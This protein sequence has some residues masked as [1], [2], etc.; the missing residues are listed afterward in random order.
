MQGSLQELDTANILQLIGW[1]QRS[2]ELWIETKDRGGQEQCWILF[3]E[4][5]SAIYAYSP[6][7]RLNRLQDYLLGL[8]L[9]NGLQ[10]TASAGF[11]S[12]LGGSMAEY[13]QLW[14]LLE[15]R[16]LHPPQV[17]AILRHMIQ[18]VLFEL[19]CLRQGEFSLNF[20]HTLSPQL[21]SLPL[22]RLVPVVQAQVRQWYRLFPH[23]PSL[24][25]CPRYGNP[26]DP[27]DS[28]FEIL[29]PLQPWLELQPAPSIRQIARYTQ[30]ELIHVVK[31][32]YEAI[33]N[34]LIVL[35]PRD[36]S[37]DN[38]PSDPVFKIMCVDD[39]ITACRSLEYILG[40]HGYQ[41]I[42]ITDPIEAIA[43]AFQ[44]QPHLI[45]CDITMPRVDGYELCAI[46]RKTRQFAQTPIIMVTSQDGYIDRSKAEISG[47]ND[48]ITKPFSEK[49]LVAVIQKQLTLPI[50]R[51]N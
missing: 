1:G 22:N 4:R 9:D 39:S 28:A 31:E 17:Q 23:I 34:D 14:L 11:V 18:E 49:Q 20:N 45:L 32:V 12:Q 37:L 44:L 43:K 38:A 51:Y 29:S 26:V 33:A 30:Q 8:N 21:I 13:E 15:E 5:G 40:K 36:R 19:L 27:D 16:V 41:V 7:D 47:S 35:I 3:F 2:G 42:S 46:F 24:D 6:Q 48:Y 50:L 10:L 25:H